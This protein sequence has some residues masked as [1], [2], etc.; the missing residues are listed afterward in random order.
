MIENQIKSQGYKVVSVWECQT[1]ELSKKYLGK[2][3]VPYPYFIVYDFEAKFKKLW[4]FYDVVLFVNS[5]Q[6]C[7]VFRVP[8]VEH[9]CLSPDILRNGSV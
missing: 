9:L 2:K 7:S 8:N 1:P 5:I 6:V 3:F 4:C